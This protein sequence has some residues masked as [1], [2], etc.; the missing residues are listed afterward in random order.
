[1]TP[2]YTEEH[3]LHQA[4][5]LGQLERVR[6]LLRAGVK[7]DSRDRFNI[8]P[9]MVAVRNRY[10]EIAQALLEAGATIN[11]KDR[12]NPVWGGKR[13]PLL[14]ASHV[15]RAEMVRFLVERGAEVNCLDSG[16][17]TPLT[18]AIQQGNQELARWLLDHGANPNGPEKCEYPPVLAAAEKNNIEMIKELLSRGAD[19]NRTGS[20]GNPALAE[21]TSSEC[22]RE[23]LCRG[24]D[25]NLKNIQGKTPLMYNL[26][27]GSFDLLKSHVEGGADVNARDNEGH[28]VLML[29]TDNPRIAVAQMLIE[30]GAEPNALWHRKCSVLDYLYR[31]GSHNYIQERIDLITFLENKGAKQAKDL[32]Q[33]RT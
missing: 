32:K 14:H 25:A 22:V 9:L 21:T 31:D 15:G 5:Q 30:A 29:L 19:P 6:E 20:W 4:A 10:R 28:T 18:Y 16:K 24:A 2:R 8:T 33:N 13:T 23:L 17:S 3:P 26:I 1:M 27:R 12:A 7:A 11:A